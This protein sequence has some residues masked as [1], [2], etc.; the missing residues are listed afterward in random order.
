VI[1]RKTLRSL[2]AA[3]AAAILSG[4]TASDDGAARFLVAPDQYVLY[5]CTQLAETAQV[6]ATRQRE[7]ELLMAKA[8]TD[9]AGRFVSGMAYQPEYA[10][11]RGQMAELR[12]EAASK[13]CRFTPGVDVPTGRASDNVV[14]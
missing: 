6:N 3:F 1:N 14:R 4:C 12:K 2:I 10:Q 9:S 5:N 13:H 11:L 7:L 8:G